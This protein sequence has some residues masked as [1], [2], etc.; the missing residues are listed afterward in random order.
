MTREK[1]IN[2]TR[3]ISLNPHAPV[4]H[5]PPNAH[6]GGGSIPPPT[7][8]EASAPPLGRVRRQRPPPPRGSGMSFEAPPQN[9][10]PLPG[11]VPPPTP[12]SERKGVKAGV[13]VLPVRTGAWVPLSPRFTPEPKPR[14]GGG[15]GH[16]QP[17]GGPRHPLPPHRPQR[18][19]GPPL[20][21][22][23]EGGV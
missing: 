21:I 14:L 18:R 9:S 22:H 12:T 10:P 5:P 1:I 19:P 3:L 2:K 7:R 23:K 11:F 4:S 8:P 16:L 20:P 13:Q 15:A 17:A 6:G